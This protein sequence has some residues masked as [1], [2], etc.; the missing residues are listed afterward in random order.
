M[1]T[2]ILA[3]EHERYRIIREINTNFFVE[4]GAGSGKTTIL[5]ERMVAMIES[6]IPVDKICAITFTK[7]AANEFYERFQKRLSER[8]REPSEGYAESPA[9]LP[10]PTDLTK[11]R[12]AE[13]LKNI[14]LCFL[15][16]IDAFCNL[17]LSEYPSESRIP[18]NAA[19][20]ET[21]AMADEYSR[22]YGLMKSG[23]YGTAVQQ[24]LGRFEKLFAYPA[25]ARQAFINLMTKMMGV[26]HGSFHYGQEALAEEDF[27]SP[28]DKADCFRLYQFLRTHPEWKPAKDTADIRTAWD[29][30]VN[31]EL[32]PAEP[33]ADQYQDVLQVLHDVSKAYRLIPDKAA[34]DREP[35]LYE[36]FEPKYNTRKKVPDIEYYTI[37]ERAGNLCRQ[38]TDQAFCRA[39]AFAERCTG[40]LA[41]QLREA[42]ILTFFDYLYYLCQA[43]Q[44]D[45]AANNGRL[46][47]QIRR[48]YEYY[49]IDEFQ[50]TDPIQAQVFFY[51]SARELDPD[52]T[53]CLAWPGSLFIVGDPKQSIYRF[54]NADITS[55]KRVENLFRREGYDVVSLTAN[56]RSLPQLCGWFNTAF[57]RIL[58]ENTDDQA[59]FEDIDA[60]RPPVPAE[61]FSGVFSYP[62][63]VLETTKK[64]T[65]RK[66]DNAE[67]ILEI[68][69][70]LT[71]NEKYQIADRDADGKTTLRTID[72]RD[73]MI[74][75]RTKAQISPISDLLTREGIACRVE[76]DMKLAEC[77]A[78]MSIM[79]IYAFIVNNDSKRHFAE[80]L[81]S[82]C[83]GYS[84]EQ[85]FAM[86]P[87][88]CRLYSEP[89]GDDPAYIGTLR[90]LIRY[91]YHMAP[92]ALLRRILDDL[93]I[94]AKTGT[95]NI[96]Y[97]YY[98]LALLREEEAGGNIRSH[99]EALAYLEEKR[100]TKNALER[101]AALTGDANRVHIANAHKVKG[102]QNRIVI[103]AAPARRTDR[104]P[105]SRTEY[106]EKPE[107]WFFELPTGTFQSIKTTGYEDKK[108][109]ETVSAEAENDRLLYVAATRAEQVLIIGDLIH[110][111]AQVP[112][113]WTTL[114]ADRNCPDI[115]SVT[116][117]SHGKRPQP[118]SMSAAALYEEAAA[119]CV[120]NDY[121]NSGSYRLKAP[122]RLPQ[123]EEEE[124]LPADEKPRRFKKDPALT[125]TLVHRLMELLV[126]SR[127]RL[128]MSALIDQVVREETADEDYYYHQ[129]LE[130]VYRQIHAGG[131]PQPEAPDD[132]LSVLLSAD[133]VHTELPFSYRDGQD[134][135][136]GTIDA[137][138]STGGQW[139]IIDFKTDYEF[140]T[141]RTQL[142]AYIEAFRQLTGES[143]DA[144]IYHIPI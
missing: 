19:A 72:Y 23:H 67:Q 89:S 60:G 104:K 36:W 73:F 20:Y 48:K 42:G 53:K 130:R 50:D 8:M 115:F 128:E 85:L 78:L 65:V 2:N 113:T 134:I 29:T 46:I 105:A 95:L 18:S 119:D 79:D 35:W 93:Q 81:K 43:L 22:Q 12:C 112:A 52:W 30:L 6:G 136:S 106:G 111:G 122:S 83:F 103:L 123:E 131:Y 3:D 118:E 129:L 5:V 97:V 63:T 1:R 137:L 55:Y 21:E 96:E 17:L 4:A 94:F 114:L 68:I 49:L 87:D 64:G 58:P 14:D 135:W 32:D 61:A 16:T 98:V 41:D 44:K 142:N 84:D 62:V 99:R 69:N 28:Q 38:L 51:L 11:Q 31:T 40:L 90:D 56:F 10:A 15:G 24:D 37:S 132:I 138:Y 117:D 33:I 74:I 140:K 108:E 141:H 25:M 126:L 7:A 9:K 120:L 102:L 86:M 107:T 45:A 75:T 26:R 127:D 109:A 100:D 66:D 116:D 82:A 143:A 77:P 57:R 101:C 71:N 70:R 80:M 121:E 39:A 76:G 91:Q 34:M 92:S 27:L 124:P 110:D 59:A 133:A 125:G 139:H 47:R 54:K 88:F 144:L 13:A